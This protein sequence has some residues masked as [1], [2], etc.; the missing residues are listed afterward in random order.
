MRLQ[1][2]V[3][4]PHSGLTILQWQVAENIAGYWQANENSRVTDMLETRTV[5]TL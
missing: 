1:S 4:M 2:F 3:V 5:A